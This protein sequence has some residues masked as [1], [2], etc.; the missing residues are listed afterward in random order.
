ME[1]ENTLNVAFAAL[2]S[3]F[4]NHGA[5]AAYLG[6]SRDHYCAIRNGRVHIPRRT[7]DLIIM[8][9]RE[10]QAHEAGIA[11]LRHSVSV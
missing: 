1:Q 7:A 11:N 2:K 6:M 10:V 9:A 8:K 5:V 3:K 4:G